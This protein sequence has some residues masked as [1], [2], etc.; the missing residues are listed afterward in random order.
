M[1]YMQRK[2]DPNMSN[3]LLDERP[4]VVLP[5]LAARVGINE[6]IF[7]QQL[8]YLLQRSTNER[9]GKRWVFNSYEAWREQFPWCS[10]R[11][12]KRTVDS[13]RSMGV[14]ETSN[15]NTLTLDR[16]LW[17]TINYEALDKLGAEPTE[18]ECQNDTSIVTDCHDHS[19]NL[20]LSEI[21]VADSAN[22]ALPITIENTIETTNIETNA[23]VQR[24]LALRFRDLLDELK[25]AGNRNAKLMEIYK[26]CYGDLDLP[27][28][29]RLGKV[30][31]RVG[32]AGRLADLLWRQTAAPPSGDVLSY[33][34]ATYV[35]QT[36]RVEP[37]SV[38]PVAGHRTAFGRDF[39]ESEA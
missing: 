39:N 20:S 13:L 28:Y 14:I 31:K 22:L 5:G 29:G 32:G 6:A 3:L 37:E 1:S 10:L 8:H 38:A 7:L 21:G 12:V 2:V 33:I 15:H 34:E 30:A 19:A 18:A 4:L 27:A 36:R 11:T 25:S 16:T 17:Y 26:L 9:D 24:P 35:R 23:A